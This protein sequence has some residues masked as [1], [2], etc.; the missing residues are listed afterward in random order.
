MIIIEDGGMRGY[1]VGDHENAGGESV[2][3]R[4]KTGPD[5]STLWGDPDRMY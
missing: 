2:A 3:K 1:C 4:D 5:C